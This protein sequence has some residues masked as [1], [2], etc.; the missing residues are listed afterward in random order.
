MEMQDDEERRELATCARLTVVGSSIIG[1]V[2]CIV[3]LAVGVPLDTLEKGMT[4]AALPWFV[5]WY[6]F[7]RVTSGIKI[8]WVDPEDQADRG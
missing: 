4:M 7:C 1:L 2:T 5:G 6:L 8:T 3:L